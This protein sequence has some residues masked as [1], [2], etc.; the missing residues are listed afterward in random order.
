[1]RER[2]IAHLGTREHFFADLRM[3]QDMTRLGTR[4]SNGYG[5]K[6]AKLDCNAPQEWMLHKTWAFFGLF[7]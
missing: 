7:G 1:M 6:N 3:G 4:K 2:N 5:D